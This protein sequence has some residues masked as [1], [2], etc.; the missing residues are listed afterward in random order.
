MKKIASLFSIAVLF[1]CTAPDRSSYIKQL[2]SLSTA[3]EATASNYE[4]LNLDEVQ[5]TIDTV[6][7]HLEFI[8]VNYQGEQKKDMSIQLSEYRSIRKLIPDLGNKREEIANNL[9]ISRSQIVDLKKAISENATHDAVGN[10][11]NDLY[12]KKILAQEISANKELVDKMNSIISSTDRVHDLFNR[13][14]SS[15]KYWVDSIRSSRTSILK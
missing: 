8:Q 2:D 6:N 5:A 10:E 9:S 14:Y 12:Y 7:S 3:I 11:M 4:T 15:V 1:S 13:H